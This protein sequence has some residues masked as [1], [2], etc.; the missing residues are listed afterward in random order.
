MD[1]EPGV[2][3]VGPF[4][5]RHEF[6]SSDPHS[7]HGGRGGGGRKEVIIPMIPTQ[8]GGGDWQDGHVRGEGGWTEIEEREAREERERRM[9]GDRNFAA[10]STPSF[11][12]LPLE[13][14]KYEGAGG[15]GS[16]GKR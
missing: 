8:G 5:D 9:Y 11:V 7:H 10:E 12:H 15:Y 14:G 4:D 13:E 2:S 16:G 3:S 1:G 6:R